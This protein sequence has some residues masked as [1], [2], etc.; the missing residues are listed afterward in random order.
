MLG[1]RIKPVPGYKSVEREAALVQGEVMLTVDTPSSKNVL[2]SPGVD[3]ILRLDDGEVPERFR[4]RPVLADLV[5]DRPVYAP[6]VA[7]NNATGRL[8]RWFAAPPATDP[9]V[10]ADWRALFAATVSHPGFVSDLGK[11]D[12]VLDPMAGAEVAGM[13]R[14]V[15]ADQER[16][17]AFLQSTLECGKSLA[18]GGDAACAHS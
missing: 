8:S 5:A 9:A 6:V 2:G 17:K 16:T 11:L 3:V 4:S 10:L 1:L 18:E 13:I 12:F 7:F 15:L 14:S